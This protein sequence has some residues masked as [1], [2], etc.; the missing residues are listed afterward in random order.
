MMP[1]LISFVVKKVNEP[2]FAGCPS[3]S[4]CLAMT[5]YLP[6]SFTLYT[7]LFFLL[8]M[9]ENAFFFLSYHSNNMNSFTLILSSCI[10]FF[11]PYP[12]QKKCSTFSLWAYSLV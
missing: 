2:E 5:S 12:H 3:I 9:L 1:H 8:I 7:T 11:R 4:I 10:L 6:A